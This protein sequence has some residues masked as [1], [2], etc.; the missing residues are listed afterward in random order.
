[1]DLSIPAPADRDD[2]AD[3]ARA[4]SCGI[5]VLAATEDEDALFDAIK[6]ARPRSS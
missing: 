2:P 5:I 4:A 3:Q 1:M 6:A